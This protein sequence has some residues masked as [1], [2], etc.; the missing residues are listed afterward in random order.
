MTDTDTLIRWTVRGISPETLNM[1]SI[2]QETS[3]GSYGQY[4]NMAITTWF[5]SLEE[6][7]AGDEDDK[8]A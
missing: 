4:V 2:V 3:G 8:A 1:L 7:D 6:D 5:D